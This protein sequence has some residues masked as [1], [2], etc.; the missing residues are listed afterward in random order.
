MLGV[1][2]LQCVRGRVAEIPSATP[3]QGKATA[4]TDGLPPSHRSI[5]AFFGGRL[6]DRIRPALLVHW[7]E[8]DNDVQVYQKLPV[9]VSYEEMMKMSKYCS[10]PSGF[11]VASPRIVEAIYAGSVPV[12]IPQH[13]VLPFSDILDWDS[14]VQGSVTEIPNLKKILMWIPQAKYLK[15]QEGV[16]QVQRHFVVNNPPKRYD[17]FSKIIHSTWLRR[18]GLHYLYVTELDKTCLFHG[19]VFLQSTYLTSFFFFAIYHGAQGPMGEPFA[20]RRVKFSL[21]QALKCDALVFLVFLV[22]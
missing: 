11:E 5:L 2:I 10:C 16:R 21:Y 3:E 14:S 19:S 9:G 8:R 20:A 7:E 6:H 17:V 12:L 1:L 15:M 22:I 4:R 13:Y 18:A